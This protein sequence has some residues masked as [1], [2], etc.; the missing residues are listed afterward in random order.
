MASLNIRT[1]VLWNGLICLWRPLKGCI[2][3]IYKSLLYC[4]C[5]LRPLHQMV[6]NCQDRQNKRY[7][8]SNRNIKLKCPRKIL[9]KRLSYI[10][11]GRPLKL[12]T[13]RPFLE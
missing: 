13:V 7:E 9:E 8:K 11:K 4:S 6:Q 3:H 12:P 2:R 1:R 10:P 5:D